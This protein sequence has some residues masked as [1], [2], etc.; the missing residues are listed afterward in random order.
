MVKR[1]AILMGVLVTSTT[2]AQ[3]LDLSGLWESSE[4]GC[5]GPAITELVKVTDDGVNY[6]AVKLRGDDCV[7]T[8]S[9]T[10]FGNRS[11]TQEMCKTVLG[12]P[13]FPSSS[14][15]SC[16]LTVIDANSFTISGIGTFT[17]VR[18][19]G[20]VNGVSL[21]KVSCK[22]S[23]TG[24]AAAGTV[25][26]AGSGWSCDQ[27]SVKAGDIVVQTLRGRAQE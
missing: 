19:S 1:R 15:G 3:A 8:G 6:Q 24:A 5:F 12:N 21:T 4:Y 9:I 25:F 2:S 14:L 7:P 16:S 10:F 22:N 20:G 13:T 18:E 11:A 26:D 27:L 17:R 23:T